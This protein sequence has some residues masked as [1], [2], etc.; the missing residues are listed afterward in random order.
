MS[1]AVLF[2]YSDLAP[3]L[4]KW[5]RYYE[6][7]RHDLWELVAEVWLKG[8]VQKL[9]DIRK[10]SQRVR[11]DMIDYMRSYDKR[12]SVY[13]MEQEEIEDLTIFEVEACADMVEIQ[14]TVRFLLQNSKL[15]YREIE[16]LEQYFWGSRTLR[17]ISEITGHSIEF[18]NGVLRSALKKLMI[19][20]EKAKFFESD[21]N[22]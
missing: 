10:V 19:T 14:D 16:V 13:R 20:A 11:Y 18:C 17:Q 4:H 1:D 8:N 2:S 9:D 5:G 6:N 3:A 21:A 7:R 12:K 22:V 15:N